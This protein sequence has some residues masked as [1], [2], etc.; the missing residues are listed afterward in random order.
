[1]KFCENQSR[2]EF[3]R[4]RGE[5]QSYQERTDIKGKDIV[6]NLHWYCE[7]PLKRKL[8]TSSKINDNIKAMDPQVMMAEIER[9]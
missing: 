8:I 1:M 2:E 9:L 7:T 6:Y 3:R 4:K 5:F